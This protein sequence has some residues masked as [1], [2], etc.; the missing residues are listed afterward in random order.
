MLFT[1]YEEAEDVWEWSPQFTPKEIACRG[2]GSLLVNPQALDVLL[3]A[4]LLA[5]RPFRIL[6]AYRSPRHNA[7]V[8]GAPKSAHK[9]GIAFDIALAGHEPDELL[10]VCR[11]AGFGSFG[12]YNTFLHVD[13]REGRRWGKWKGDN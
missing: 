13:L 3:R 2:D 10:A 11:A 8:G 12:K 1:H 5:D 7:L 4:R 6:S 9:D